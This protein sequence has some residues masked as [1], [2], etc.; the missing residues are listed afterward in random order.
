[1]SGSAVTC[2]T[3]LDDSGPAASA[4]RAAAACSTLLQGC[5]A[6]VLAVPSPGA[7]PWDSGVAAWG[8]EPASATALAGSLVS[9]SAAGSALRADGG[10]SPTLSMSALEG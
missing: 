2:A 3:L 5:G 6:C 8:P 9:G 10:A 1:M 4:A 7:L